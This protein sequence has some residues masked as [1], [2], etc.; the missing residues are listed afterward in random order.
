MKLDK[1]VIDHIEMFDHNGENISIINNMGKN[2]TVILNKKD[3]GIQII[4]DPAETKTKAVRIGSLKPGDV[5]AENGVEYIVI[6]NKGRAAGM[7]K[8]IRKEVLETAM[9]FGSKTNNWKESELKRY[10]NGE[11][12]DELNKSFGRTNIISH[13]VGLLSLDGLGD[14][15]EDKVKVGLL[16]IDGY[17][18]CR[19]IIGGTAGKPWW[20]ITPDST[21]SGRGHAMV[22]YVGGNGCITNCSYN[23]Q[24]MFV[25][26][27]FCLYADKVVNCYD[28]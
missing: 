22:Q 18:S 14:Y 19:N 17:R 25:R 21:D 3:G 13:N 16:D 26:P 28:D 20:L 5:F 9:V 24:G 2:V 12:L 6:E 4:I 11:Y 23:V 8:V 7:V 27:V 10:L 1:N 15:G